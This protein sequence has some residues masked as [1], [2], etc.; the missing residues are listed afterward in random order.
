MIHKKIKIYYLTN[1]QHSKFIVNMLE[2]Y[3]WNGVSFK[4]IR[5]NETNYLTRIG[6]EVRFPFNLS[7]LGMQSLI[8]HMDI[9]QLLHGGMMIHEWLKFS[10]F[11]L[12]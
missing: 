2:A 5:S 10:R 1:I 9:P 3:Q 8:Q 7:S 4:I 6:D 11:D 12:H